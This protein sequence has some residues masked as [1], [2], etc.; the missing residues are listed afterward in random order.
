MEVPSRAMALGV[1]AKLRPDSVDPET[2]I[3][4]NARSYVENGRRYLRELRR[5]S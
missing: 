5:I 3:L 4:A 1:P 2:M